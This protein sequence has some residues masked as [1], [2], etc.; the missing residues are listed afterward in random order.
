MTVDWLRQQGY[1]GWNVTSDI[2]GVAFNAKY[3]HY[4]CRRIQAGHDG[5]T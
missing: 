5:K 4:E 1:E 3:V 2:V